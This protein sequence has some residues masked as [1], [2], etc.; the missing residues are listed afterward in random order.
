MRVDIIP[1]GNSKGLR[2]SKAIL[3]QCGIEDSVNLEIKDH[4]IIITP[5][6]QKPRKDW[7][8]AFQRMSKNKDDTLLDDEN[9]ISSWDKTDWTW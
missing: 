9:E 3:E 1:I 5:Y 2:F 7:G 4:T 8:D 6:N